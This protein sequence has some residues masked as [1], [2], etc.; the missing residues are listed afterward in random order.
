[1]TSE[2]RTFDEIDE[3]ISKIELQN[4]TSHIV[5]S[6]H[7]SAPEVEEGY[8]YVKTSDIEN[9][10][11]IFD[12]VAY[13]DEEAYEEWTRRLVPEPG[14]IV[15]TR[16]APVGR[17]GIVPDG[18]EICLG[19]RTVLIRVIPDILDNQYLRYLLLSE[20]IQNR[21]E[22]LS[23]G[24]T[25]D[26]LNLT[27][28]RSFE[29]YDL[30]PIEEQKIIGQILS[31]FDKK[32][33]LNNKIEK[34]L[35]DGADAIFKDWFSDFSP[36]DNFKN[37][38]LGEIPEEFEVRE[39]GDVLSLEYGDGLPKKEREGDQY[40]VYGSNGVTGR[41][42]EYLI[43]G[44]G[45]VVGRKGTIGT[46]KLCQEEFWCIDT[47]F[48]VDP[49]MD[50]DMLY[51]Y[52][53]LKDGVALKHLG[54]DSAVPGLNRNMVHDVEAPIPP[55][56]EIERFVKMVRPFYDKIEEIKKENENLEALRDTLL[57]KLMSGEIRVDDIKLDELEVDSEV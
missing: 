36:Y 47:T 46:V 38:G 15:L 31:Q 21:F 18:K 48:Y 2:Q 17:V 39:I 27:D 30:P 44:P 16:E 20:D 41:H 13:V 29:L 45:I 11:I 33:R 37:T 7:K 42:N 53:L 56:E 35:R 6:E 9:G 24:S 23:S 26:H 55:I 8:P 40:P 43:E 1:M 3:D 19:Q 49:K 57:P 12:D 5:D 50:A 22:A 51:F 32:I 52:H 28:L 54:S 34:N 25:V 10:R 4:A 14:D